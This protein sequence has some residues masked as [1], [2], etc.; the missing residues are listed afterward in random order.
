MAEPEPDVKLTKRG[1]PDKRTGKDGSSRKNASRAREKINTLVSAGKAHDQLE[2]DDSD[3]EITIQKRAPKRK[4]PRE[5]TPSPDRNMQKESQ[6]ALVTELAALRREIA[7]LR[8][9]ELVVQTPDPVATIRRQ[10]LMRF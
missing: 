5:H 4:P 7:D 8:K 9:P 3:L 6:D 10:I 2:E 1:I